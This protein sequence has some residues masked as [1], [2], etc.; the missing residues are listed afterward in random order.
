M[1]KLNIKDFIKYLE[2]H[3]GDAYVWGAQGQCL[4]DMDDPESWIESRETSSTNANRAIAFMKKARKKPLYAFDCSGLG[5]YYIQNMHKL[6][7]DLS[8][9]SMYNKCKK[10]S[11][12]ELQCG[13]MVFRHN[14]SKVYHVG[15]VVDDKLNVIES[16]GRD[17]GV[18]KRPLNASGSAYWNRYGRPE[19]AFGASDEDDDVQ[20][21]AAAIEVYNAKCSGSKVNVRTGR[22]TSH[23][24]LGKLEKHA[25]MLALS[26]QDGWCEIACYLDGKL[27]LGYMSAQYVQKS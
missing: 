23:K 7:G 16:M 10:I 2:S 20:E 25:P 11:R 18:V 12:D 1:G 8:S 24:S 6:S 3:V 4:S 26:K 19:W 9:A 21:Q 5:M 17:V 13:D 15:Y 14:G 27:Q 22:G